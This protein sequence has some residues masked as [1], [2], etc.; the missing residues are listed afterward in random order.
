[1]T[2]PRRRQ[3]EPN[4]Q[5]RK[6]AGVRESLA[7]HEFHWLFA[8]R[9]LLDLLDNRSGVT[10]VKVEGLAVEDASAAPQADLVADLTTYSGGESHQSATVV[11]IEQFKYSVAV[12]P[13]EWTFGKLRQTKSG[14]DGVLLRFVTAWK[15]AVAGGWSDKLTLALVSN[16]PLSPDVQQSHRDVVDGRLTAKGAQKL[17]K[18]TGLT[19]DE[20]SHFLKRVEFQCGEAGRIMQQI[21]LF[22]RVQRHFMTIPDVAAAKL[23]DFVF[24]MAGLDGANVTIN[25]D[26]LLFELGTSEKNLFPCPPMFK[27]PAG[28]IQTRYGGELAAELRL[29]RRVVVHAGAGMGKSTTLQYLEA[30]LPEG[31]VV[32]LYDCYGG[33]ASDVE[34]AIRSRTK[35][36]VIQTTNE[37]AHR[38]LAPLLLRGQDDLEYL[39]RDFQ[40]ILFQ[41]ATATAVQGGL[42]V[43]AADA[44]D[45]AYDAR[46]GKDWFLPDLDRITWPDAARLVISSRSHRL[47]DLPEAFQGKQFEVLGFNCSQSSEHLRQYWPQATDEEC[48]EF[49][50]R[51]RGRTSGESAA[52]RVQEYAITSPGTATATMAIANAKGGWQELMAHLLRDFQKHFT[53]DDGNMATAAAAILI[54]GAS[55]RHFAWLWN[56]SEAAAKTRL[57]AL[58]PGLIFAGDAVRFGD[59]E[60]EEHFRSLPDGVAM[61]Q[62]HTAISRALHPQ[63]NNDALCANRIAGFLS[64][65]GLNDE[66]IKLALTEPEL[67]ENLY[68]DPRERG[69]VAVKRVDLAL[70]AAAGGLSWEDFTE[71]CVVR[72][73]VGRVRVGLL[74]LFAANPCVAARFQ[75]HEAMREAVLRS[76]DRWDY[77]QNA[78]NYALVLATCGQADAARDY[79]KR[80]YDALR[81]LDREERWHFHIDHIAHYVH[82]AYLL[83]GLKLALTAFT[84]WRIGVW[85]GI[86][87]ALRWK[88][89]ENTT[90]AQRDEL[91]ANRRIPI[92]FRLQFAASLWKQAG[93][94]SAKSLGALLTWLQ[95]RPPGKVRQ[96]RK[97]M[98]DD[99]AWA[100][101]VAICEAAVAA[102]FSLKRISKIVRRHLPPIPAWPAHGWY[103]W[104][105]GDWGAALRARALLC[106]AAGTELSATALKEESKRR[107]PDE[108]PGWDYYADSFFSQAVSITADRAAVLGL[109]TVA[110]H[111]DRFSPRIGRLKDASERKRWE[112]GHA[113]GARRQLADWLVALRRMD[114]C[115]SGWFAEFLE[116]GVSLQAEGAEALNWLQT[117]AGISGEFCHLEGYADEAHR[118]LRGCI[119]KA[120]RATCGQQAKRDLLLTV[121][122]AAQELTVKQEAWEAAV[123]YAGQCDRDDREIF[124][125]LLELSLAAG[126]ASPSSAPTLAAEM[127]CWAERYRLITDGEHFP[128]DRVFASLAS[129]HFPTALATLARWM[130]GA[131][132][133]A[134]P[135]IRNIVDMAVS[136]RV[137]SSANGYALLHLAMPQF[138]DVQMLCRLL[139]AAPERTEEERASKQRLLLSIVEFVLRDMP[140]LARAKAADTL[141][142]WVEKTGR[143][144]LECM[145]RL[146][147]LQRFMAT[148]D[149]GTSYDESGRSHISSLSDKKPEPPVGIEELPAWLAEQGNYYSSAVI[150]VLK[151]WV[152]TV[153]AVRHE[154]LLGGIFG[155]GARE[156][157]GDVALALLDQLRGRIAAPVL[158]RF[159]TELVALAAK[160]LGDIGTP[161]H[162]RKLTAILP[163]HDS[164]GMTEEA[165]LAAAIAARVEADEYWIPTLVIAAHTVRYCGVQQVRDRLEQRL[166]WA[167]ARWFPEDTPISVE[168]V[169]QIPSDVQGTLAGFYWACFTHPDKQVRCRALYAVLETT[170]LA[171]DCRDLI[172]RLVA[173]AQATDTGSFRD[174]QQGP[175]FWISG[176]LF[177]WRLLRRLAQDQPELLAPHVNL[178][179][180]AA[181]DKS[182]PHA[183][184]RE[185]ARGT[186]LALFEAGIP[187]ADEV[188]APILR[189]NRPAAA[190]EERVHPPSPP[191][192]DHRYDFRGSR[193]GFSDLDTIPNWFGGVAGVFG[194]LTPDVVSRADVWVCDRWGLTRNE[195][196]RDEPRRA[197]MTGDNYG[198]WSNSHGQEPELENLTHY[199]PY[200]AMFCVAGEL[201]DQGTLTAKR[202]KW[203][204]DLCRFRDWLQRWHGHDDAV[205]WGRDLVSPPPYSPLA[206]GI[207]PTREVACQPLSAADF[208]TPLRLEEWQNDWLVV[209]G[210]EGGWSSEVGHRIYMV[211]YLVDED[212]AASFAAAAQSR[213]WPNQRCLPEEKR[214]YHGDDSDAGQSL[215]TWKPLVITRDEDRRWLDHD[216]FLQKNYYSKPRPSSS[217]VE[218]LKAS[219]TG[220][221]RW[222]AP[223]HGEFL[224]GQQWNFQERDYRGRT[225]SGHGGHLCWFRA[226]TLLAILRAERK[227]AVIMVS[228][229]RNEEKNDLSFREDKVFH[230][231]RDCALYYVLRAD[232]TLANLAGT[233]RLGEPVAGKP[234]PDW[235]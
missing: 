28:F 82:T 224:V 232:T 180:S 95:S 208:D 47:T 222:T 143:G 161:V 73:E 166:K 24:R 9:R 162:R 23:K 169:R 112:E 181:L 179:A 192:Y 80:G 32:I 22:G 39:L 149:L 178:L 88:L 65:A 17:I 221:E 147:N 139:E 131:K 231:E 141:I 118:F 15:E 69:A 104:T 233:R 218:Q 214:T 119:H 19:V 109:K 120:G 83:G 79:L 128:E 10:A 93:Y 122:T 98:A 43:I 34:R 195:T 182:L 151:E 91:L 30:A 60:F 70:A 171:N 235:R 125:D 4:T 183:L 163:L 12:Q 201:I 50:L 196:W 175:C 85:G 38:G 220:F 209:Q 129:L 223:G 186:L 45:D 211:T 56:V 160:C 96:P 94:V 158:K 234:W 103:E 207:L 102:G 155:I 55:L 198:R 33:G 89:A 100:D 164:A 117:L 59:K 229:R 168:N 48:R 194:M 172:Q 213:R 124:G 99:G 16:A 190:T 113:E 57:H 2:E 212:L 136:Q 127:V 46:K 75:G 92:R 63:R 227:A 130:D 18:A 72:A 6:H 67:P 110:E 203:D 138:T 173:C 78:W 62:A 86:V 116:C 36:F 8:A 197:H 58:A 217:V 90:P 20:A 84:H 114:G 74:N 13:P 230:P 35:D 76:P 210:N 49:H 135:G 154:E 152:I 142:E 25:R 185:L 7:G 225:E 189:L 40:D 216:P 31:S 41:A 226:S 184:I 3:P 150:S 165:F 37:L 61:K 5:A 148:H 146:R 26:M 157:G 68:P 202:S 145:E 52:P 11:R 111:K 219:S 106:L 204:E 137:I 1:V 44:V 177:L 188:K 126:A 121:A 27:M 64:A 140:Y 21:A 167:A 66:L 115:D 193:F 87:G 51:T 123:R 71:L 108:Q 144:S 107:C 228:I 199:A 159:S 81:I 174:P 134:N 105:A 29:H 170:R 14:K 153:P 205:T 206:W 215:F 77:P 101:I 156:H 176:R 133:E 53:G 54:P 200:H 132:C 191:G 97:H 42:L 187:V